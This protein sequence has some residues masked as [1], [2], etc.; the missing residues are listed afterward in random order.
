MYCDELKWVSLLGVGA[1]LYR[2][3][4]VGMYP[5]S[6]LMP[7]YSGIIVIWGTLY[8]EHWKREQCVRS[9]MWGTSSFESSETD[10]YLGL[11]WFI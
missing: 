8:L 10:R 2:I 6:F 1:Y 5:E 4:V 3:I 11:A 7:V 9:M